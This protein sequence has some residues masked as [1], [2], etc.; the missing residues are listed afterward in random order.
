MSVSYTSDTKYNEINDINKNVTNILQRVIYG[1]PDVFGPIDEKLVALTLFSQLMSG[2]EKKEAARKRLILEQ[3]LNAILEK[4]EYQLRAFAGVAGQQ[5]QG[6]L[7]YKEKKLLEQNCS[8]ILAT[9]GL[10]VSL[11]HKRWFSRA[12]LE[13]VE[14][15]DGNHQLIP[16]VYQWLE[17]W[18]TDPDLVEGDR[19]G[20]YYEWDQKLFLLKIQMERLYRNVIHPTGHERRLDYESQNIAYWIRSNFK[21]SRVLWKDP[22]IRLVNFGA[23]SLDFE[24]GFYVDNM[25]LEH[26][27][28]ADRI[29]DELRREIKTRF[30]E[31]GIEIPF[32]QV[33]TWSRHV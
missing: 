3:N 2:D 1:H 27:R 7:N 31:A 11:V 5:E 8:E 25:K 4:L 14:L 19:N 9:F 26:Y 17:A 18:S 16:L 20:L 32:P 23:S 6:G 15:I 13:F 29:K 30:D 10:K 12:K 24:V 33:D 28:R 21:E 22:D